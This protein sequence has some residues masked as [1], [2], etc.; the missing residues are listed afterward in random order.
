MFKK[1]Q[2]VFEKG[3][4]GAGGG[5]GGER[6]CGESRGKVAPKLSANRLH[7]VAAATL[8]QREVGG[9]R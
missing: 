4:P 2:L 9:H 8:W 3:R 6:A 1:Q 5:G 7:G